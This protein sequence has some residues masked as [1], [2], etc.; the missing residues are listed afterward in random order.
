MIL[1]ILTLAS[2]CDFSHKEWAFKKE[3]SPVDIPPKKERSSKRSLISM[4]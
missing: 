4:S 1:C 2:N 3:I